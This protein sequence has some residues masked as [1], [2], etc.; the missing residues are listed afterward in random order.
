MDVDDFEET[1]GLVGIFNLSFGFNL[2]SDENP[3]MPRT[4]IHI[5]SDDEINEDFQS[6]SS[7]SAEWTPKS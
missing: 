2:A 4:S 3:L 5:G 7:T 6:I 1:R